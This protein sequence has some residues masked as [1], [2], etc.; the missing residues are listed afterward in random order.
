MDASGLGFFLLLLPVLCSAL[1]LLRMATKDALRPRLKGPLFL[2][3]SYWTLTGGLWAY[4]ILSEQAGNGP[5]VYFLVLAFL[6]PWPLF[7][8]LFYLYRRAKRSAP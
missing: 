5:A 6:G 7:L 2:F 8:L 3:V 1:L 4:V